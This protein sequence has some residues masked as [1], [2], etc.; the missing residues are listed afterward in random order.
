MREAVTVSVLRS[1]I[2]KPRNGV[3]SSIHPVH[4]S[5]TRDGLRTMCEGGG[6][7]NAI[8]LEPI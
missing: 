1:P 8:V 3:L 7:A 2:G 6:M 4:L 5:A